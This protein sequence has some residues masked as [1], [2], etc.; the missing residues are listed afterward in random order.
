M[1]DLYYATE[2]E[3]ESAVLAFISQG[4]KF[5]VVGRKHIIVINQ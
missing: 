1:Q 3:T 5:Q 4:V 2:A